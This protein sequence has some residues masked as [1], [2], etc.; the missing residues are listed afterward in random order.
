MGEVCCS[1]GQCSYAKKC[2]NAGQTRVDGRICQSDGSWKKP[3]GESCYT[4]SDCVTWNCADNVC[5]NP[6]QCGDG[7]ARICFN[8][9]QYSLDQSK[10]CMQDIEGRVGWKRRDGQSC[11]VDNHC[12]SGNCA[13]GVCCLKDHC[14]YEGRC[15]ANGASIDYGICVNST[16]KEAG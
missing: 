15:Y 13:D 3:W 6:N 1:R 7:S 16:W 5:C 11:S 10:V 9:G 4:D 14:G 2:Y 8:L 12:A